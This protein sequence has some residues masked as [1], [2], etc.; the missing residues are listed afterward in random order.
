M[1]ASGDALTWFCIYGVYGLAFWYGVK[2]MLEDRGQPDP[3]YTG[4]VLVTVLF[5]IVMGSIYFGQAAPYFEA[6]ALARGAAAKVFDIID[7]KSL[8]D[9]S[10]ENG[11]RLSSL[12]GSIK[13]SDVYFSYPARTSVPVLRGLSLTVS[14]GE[15][16]A[17]VG[18]SGCGKSTVVQLI[19]RFYDADAGSVQLDGHDVKDL[20]IGWLRDNIGLVGQEPVLFSTTIAENIKLGKRGATDEE[21]IAAA[22]IANAHSFIEA[23]PLQ[24]NTLVGERGTQLSGGQK[25]RI[26]IARALVRNPK[27]LLLD[28]A[29]SALDTESEAVVQSALDQARLGRTTIIIAHR[30]STIKTADKIVV[31]SDGVI[32]EV[33]THDELMD[34]KGSYYQLI[35]TQTKESD[36]EEEKE[37]PVLEAQTDSAII[38]NES[39]EGI[40]LQDYSSF[41]R[42]F[43]NGFHAGMAAINKTEIPVMGDDDDAEDEKAEVSKMRLLRISAPEWPYAIIGGLS[44]MLIGLHLPLIGVIFGEMLGVF[45]LP[46]EM[47]PEKANFVCLMFLIIS[48]TAFIFSFLQTFMLS[49]VGERLTTRLRKMI[50]TNIITQDIAFFDHPKNSVGSLC[51]RLTN[52]ASHVQGATGSRIATGLHATSTF[53]ACLVIG[54]WYSYKMG[55]VIFA[56]V[57]FIGIAFYLEGRVIS[58]HM[59]VEEA[60]FE[61]ASKIAIEAI[62]SIRTVASLHE[63][64]TFFIKFHDA[65]LEPHKKSRLKSQIRGIIYGF[66]QSVQAFAYAAGIY[67]GCILVANDEIAYSDL[68][69]VLEGVLVG[70]MMVGETIGFAPDYHKAKVG[71]IRIFKL[72]DLKPR[73]H[74]FSEHG[75]TLENIEGYIRFEKVRFRY[76]SRPDVRVLNGLNF[77]IEPGKT[78]ALVGS[79]GCGKSTC[80]QLIER[81]YD[82]QRG[83]VIID[84]EN[85]KDMNVTDL[86]SHIGL[87]SQEPILFSYS[88]AEN[89]AYGDNTQEMDM[90]RVISA[91]RQANIH[92]FITTLPKGYD[93]PLGERGTQLSGGQKQRVAIARALLRNPKILLLDEA[94]SALDAE[95]EKIVQEAL[96]KA[97]TGRTCLIIAHRLTTIQNADTIMVIHKGR[98]VEK[99]THQELLNQRGHYYKLQ[100]REVGPLRQEG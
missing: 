89:I 60:G 13:F 38:L 97:R 79:S 23:L 70:I 83:K 11:L 96:D 73:I 54:F 80:V 93:T 2:L 35:L 12:Q 7:R 33:G 39:S 25:Q 69:K 75:K 66:V 4:G 57:P 42:P 1:T 22:K 41:R 48:S 8:I 46:T 84:K 50:F 95:S 21:V 72:L 45:S 85:V 3:E 6:L 49:F 67:Y 40:E 52:D 55:F 77:E 47:I 88:I 29:T 14:P 44:A 31:V 36:E 17:L 19:L 68:M 20:N 9:S 99:G 86:R 37:S 74:I 58:S 27:I 32:K 51:S 62:E 24:Y 82:V 34:M 10:S 100:N 26:A 76:P 92:N 61:A 71:A 18:A 81:F 28:E 59:F 64:K 98:I 5:N 91:A 87:V 30:L 16:V 43:E 15:T 78:V 63:E 65:L 94:T 56:F 90:N 53:A